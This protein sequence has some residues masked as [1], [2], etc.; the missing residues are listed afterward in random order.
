MQKLE[1]NGGSN[2]GRHCVSFR[3]SMSKKFIDQ[4][5]DLGSTN[6]SFLTS[7]RFDM[8]MTCVRHTI[9]HVFKNKSGTSDTCGM[10]I[11]NYIEGLS[12][13]FIILILKIKN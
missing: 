12:Q 3:M 11:F 1:G 8:C 13:P 5:C 2:V 10:L 9:L 4:V 6:N 7:T